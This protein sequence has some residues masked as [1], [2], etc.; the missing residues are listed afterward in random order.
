MIAI[1]KRFAKDAGCAGL[2]STA[3]PGWSKILKSDGY[4]ASWVAFELPLDTE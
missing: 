4:T 1:L 3:R 2:E